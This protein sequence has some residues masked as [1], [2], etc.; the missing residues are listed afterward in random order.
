MQLAFAKAVGET[1]KSLEQEPSTYL[2]ALRADWAAHAAGRPPIEDCLS[3]FFRERN[4]LVHQSWSQVEPVASNDDYRAL[5][6]RIEFFAD[7]TLFLRSSLESML[8]RKLSEQGL[9]A[10][11]IDRRTREITERLPAFRTVEVMLPRR[12]QS[13]GGDDSP[14]LRCT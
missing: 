8:L 1:R 11:E 3:R 6:N 9:T 10:S 4:W 13:C 5:A 7:E 2:D 14:A 12:R